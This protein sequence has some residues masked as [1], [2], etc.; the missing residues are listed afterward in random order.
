[1]QDSWNPPYWGGWG[2]S[3]SA[4]VQG[5]EFS[6]VSIPELINPIL[7]YYTLILFSFLGSYYKLGLK[8]S[9]DL[10]FTGLPWLGLRCF[11]SVTSVF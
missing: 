9:F 8:S 7:E 4:N 5:R 1:M 11:L 10:E 6:V 2:S 3:A